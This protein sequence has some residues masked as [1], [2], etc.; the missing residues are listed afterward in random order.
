M[1]LLTCIYFNY[2]YLLS[3][4]FF[5]HFYNKTVNTKTIVLYLFV[6]DALWRIVKETSYV[7]AA[8]V[9]NVTE[10]YTTPWFNSQVW[11]YV[12]VL[13]KFCSV[14]FCSDQVSQVD[15]HDLS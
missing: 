1:Y 14:L 6:C 7:S 12:H 5:H 11:S 2:L 9:P 4:G 3:D 10:F 15:P 8:H 13:N